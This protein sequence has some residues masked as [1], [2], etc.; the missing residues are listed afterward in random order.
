MDN[1]AFLG[2]A[3]GLAWVVISA[4]LIGILRRQRLIEK[5]LDELSRERGRKDENA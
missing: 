2:I 5:K 4:Y 3:Y 1:L